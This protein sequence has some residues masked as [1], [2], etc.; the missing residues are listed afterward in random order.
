MG[1][2]T[3]D[4][5]VRQTRPTWAASRLMGLLAATLGLQLLLILLFRAPWG[6]GGGTLETRA[7]VPALEAITPVRLELGGSDGES[8]TLDKTGDG[9]GIA[10][11]GGFPADDE[12]VQKLID[13]LE[14]LRV[15]RPVVTSSRYHDA[16]KVEDDDHE[17]RVRLWADAGAEPKLDLIVGDSPNYRVVHLRLAGEDA[18]YEARGLAAYDLQPQTT[19]WI[20]K[21]LAGA[22]ADN[23]VGLEL[24]NARGRFRVDKV[25]GA[26]KVVSP[27]GSAGD[28]L[29]TKKV[30]DLVRS[31]AA[32]RLADAA[33]ARDDGAH[34]LSAP[35]ATVTLRWTAD[36]AG[37]TSAESP[38]DVQEVTL[39]IGGQVP[40]KTSQRYV[41]RTGLAYTGTIWES[42]VTTFLEK[43]LADLLAS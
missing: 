12:K 23:V 4:A 34:G 10:G 7:L 6:D 42:S 27:E 39:E 9:W 40:D 14:A 24:A 30:E 13:D 32:L 33:G 26:W 20:R 3:S 1:H 25:D 38:A 41:G 21:E 11:L 29:D 22:A 19:S 28:V 18:V 35:A 36:G 37:A 15:R 16:F 2:P 17:G 8:I 31:A 5:R 43:Q